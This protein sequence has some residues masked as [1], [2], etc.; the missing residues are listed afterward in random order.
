MQNELTYQE[1]LIVRLSAHDYEPSA[2]CAFLDVS[3]INLHLLKESIKTKLKCNNWYEVVIKAF[4]LNLIEKEDFIP[5]F[6][7]DGALKCVEN[8]MQSY[9]MFVLD[10]PYDYGQITHKFKTLF[11]E[12]YKQSQ[13][14]LFQKNKYDFSLK[15]IQFIEYTYLRYDSNTIETHLDLTPG[16]YVNLC[17]QLFLKLESDEW[18][19]CIRKAFQYRL[20]S[21]EKYWNTFD[22]DLL[23]HKLVSNF[24]QWIDL[25]ETVLIKEIHGRMY[26]GI[27]KLYN[28]LEYNYLLRS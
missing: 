2:I 17:Y 18:F 23:I 8:M 13:H 9:Y 27:I 3:L 21:K 6:V 25:E 11:L 15:E 20:L 7:K 5:E 10:K 1:L 28:H 14:I 4:K 22:M 12:F 26:K 16:E 24:L 19:N